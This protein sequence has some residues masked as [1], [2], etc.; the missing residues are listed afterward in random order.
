[1]KLLQLHAAVEGPGTRHLRVDGMDA[2]RFLKDGGD[3]RGDDHDWDVVGLLFPV[4][5]MGLGRCAVSFQFPEATFEFIDTGEERVDGRGIRS[6]SMAVAVGNR[7]A[8]TVGGG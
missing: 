2:M 1:M 6:H 8:V 3:H 5:I 7:L 4:F